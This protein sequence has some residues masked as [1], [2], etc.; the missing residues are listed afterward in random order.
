MPTGDLLMADD[1]GRE[2]HLR[3]RME[4]RVE[5]EVAEEAEDLV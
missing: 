3:H 1:V 5:K 4:D 2:N